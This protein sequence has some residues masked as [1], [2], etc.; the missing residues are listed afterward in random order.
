V[1]LP[2]NSERTHTVTATV[3]RQPEQPLIHSATVE[4]PANIF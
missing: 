1:N 2:A 4:A 3:A